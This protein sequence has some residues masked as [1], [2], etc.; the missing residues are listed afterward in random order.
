M[1]WQRRKRTT[2][3]DQYMLFSTNSQLFTE[4]GV[5]LPFF[6]HQTSLCLPHSIS[7]RLH[8]CLYFPLLYRLYLKFSPSFR[9]HHSLSLFFL[10]FLLNSLPPFYR[11]PYSLLYIHFPAIRDGPLVLKDIDFSVKGGE[12]IGIAGRTG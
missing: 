2:E 8:L 5:S 11:L 1:I 12:K 10:S 9:F 7:N 4:L 3:F 6:L